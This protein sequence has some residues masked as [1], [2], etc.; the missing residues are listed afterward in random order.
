MEKLKQN[1]KS[2]WEKMLLGLVLVI[3]MGG[4]LYV[5]FKVPAIREQLEQ[6]VGRDMR[7]AFEPEDLAE[8]EQL[9]TR[10]EQDK[11]VRLAGP[12]HNTFNP[13]G[14][15]D[16]NGNL[17]K[18]K[19]YGRKGPNAVAIRQTSPLHLRIA[20]DDRKE[21][22][23]EDPRYSFYVTREAAS[24]KSDRRKVT[25]VAR[26]REKNDIFILR[27]VKGSPT[28][29]ESFVLTLLNSN[30]N[31]EVSA[32][33]E[34]TEVRGYQ[35]D[36]EYEAG[37]RKFSGVMKGDSITIDKRNYEIVFISESEVVL[38]D[39]RTSTHVSILKSGL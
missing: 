19:F 28:S 20:Y 21:V 32:T 33:S 22:S 30:Q 26:L 2:H 25:R 35:A 37:N 7:K 9:I 18:D 3:L 5:V 14:W 24:K 34:F 11:G 15:Q 39:E 29:P 8:V 12:D 38:A 36:L 23:S 13:V 16:V 1:F 10:S 27:E 17:V 4:G 6:S 31:I